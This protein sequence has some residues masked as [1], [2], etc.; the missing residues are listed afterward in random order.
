MTHSQ[1]TKQC[2]SCKRTLPTSLFGITM[3]TSDAYNPDCKSCRNQ[4]RRDSYRKRSFGV[5]LSLKVHNKSRLADID[6]KSSF[7]FSA[8][9]INTDEIVFV[10]FDPQSKCRLLEFRNS[11]NE[12]LQGF[13][14]REQ[15]THLMNGELER[16][17]IRDELRIFKSQDEINQ[18]RMYID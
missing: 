6:F 10:S 18:F 1:N 13:I 8:F 7:K 3:S 5:R 12:L 11:N 4:K 16:M 17:L 15:H 2:R 14:F 9:K